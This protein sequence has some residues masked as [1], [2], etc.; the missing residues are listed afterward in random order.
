MIERLNQCAVSGLIQL[1]NRRASKP[2]RS[3]C[4]ALHL[5]VI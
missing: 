1:S 2:F 4:N 5:H 3:K